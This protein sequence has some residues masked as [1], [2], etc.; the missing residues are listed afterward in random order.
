MVV[1][2]ILASLIILGTT[3]WLWRYHRERFLLL[4]A[5]FGLMLFELLQAMLVTW[6]LLEQEW[7]LIGLRLL[8]WGVLLKA[9]IPGWRIVSVVIGVLLFIT[10]LPLI[11]G[12]DFLM[13]GYLT[14]VPLLSLLTTT[15]QHQIHLPIIAPSVPSPFLTSSEC[16]Q[17]HYHGHD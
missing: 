16:D 1:F 3:T 12:V 10:V 6:G 9:A 11:P 2:H 5:L 15:Q 7:L 8:A 17:Q 13:W 14:A 4:D